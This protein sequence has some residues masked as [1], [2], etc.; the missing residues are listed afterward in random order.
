MPPFVLKID[1]TVDDVPADR[2]ADPVYSF[3]PSLMGPAHEFRLTPA[4]LE[5]RIG[6]HSGRVPYRDIRRLRLSFRPV[7][8]AWHRFLTEIW[9]EGTPKLQIA[10]TSWRGIAEQQRQ[11]A[12]YAAFIRSLHAQIVS[13]GAAARLEAGS[14]PWLYWPGVLVFVG[15]ALAFAALIVR[16]LQTASWAGVALVAAF[17][18]AFVWQ[19][20]VF[21]TRNRPGTY[22]AD[23]IPIAVLPRS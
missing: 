8:L 9:A 11:D 3:K 20:G 13:R 19:L 23:A 22:R 16:G 12:A 5:W 6:R 15:V 1:G 18:G 10:S 2:D 4:A 17:L 14:P 21:F 7:S